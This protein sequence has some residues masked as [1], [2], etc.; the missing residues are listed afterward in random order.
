MTKDYVITSPL[1]G[2]F[3]SRPSPEEEPFVEIGKRVEKD[4]ICCIVETMKVFNDVRTEKSGVIKEILVEDE[5]L[6]MIN[7]PL[8]IIE[9]D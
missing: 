6:V 7:Q 3:Y 8:M 5:D 2:V 4:M 9:P 1:S